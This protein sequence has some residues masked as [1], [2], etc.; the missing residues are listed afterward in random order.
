MI[1]TPRL[2]NPL[3]AVSETD[4]AMSKL[5]YSGLLRS[6]NEGIVPDLAARYEVSE[7]LLEYRFFLRDELKFHDGH[8]LTVDDIIFTISLAQ[9]PELKSPKR[10]NW[11][12]ITL[13]KISERE[14]VFKLDQPYPP[15][16]QNLDIGILP[17][18]VWNNLNINEITLTNININPV[19]SGPYKIARANRDELGI[20][21][22]YVLESF[23]DFAL[24]EPNIKKLTIKFAKN[25]NHLVEL[26]TN[27][28]VDSIY[29]LGPE[30]AHKLQLDGKRI[31]EFTLPRIFAIFLNQS[32]NIVLSNSAVRQALQL[33]TPRN[34]IVNDVLFG[35]ATVADGP[36]PQNYLDFLDEDFEMSSS[37]NEENNIEEAVKILE[38]N[39]W[40]K[41]DEGIMIKDSNGNKQMLSLTI[42]T[43]NAP[44]L[45]KI[46]EV[47][48]NSW[49]EIGAQVDVRVFN[50]SDLSGT[51]IRPRNF[52]ALLFGLIVGRDLDFYAFWHSSQRNDP[53]LNIT[54]YANIEVD[55]T[56]EDIRNS[57]DS[58]LIS[59]GIIKIQSEIKKDIPAIFI[60]SPN[61]I[62]LIPDRL[63]NVNIQNITSAE[64]RFNTVNDWYLETR[65]VWGFLIN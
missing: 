25:Q 40:E 8:P 17:M 65:K 54:S 32:E 22:L 59:S 26:F 24:G 41:N 57:N 64:E 20:P 52:E 50:Q 13:E 49:R 2:I 18:H 29:G 1:G 5:I 7:D 42:S 47:V 51:V 53:G 30:A 11:E 63:K 43:S 55:K 62:Y 4:K 39:G 61:F 16:L 3:L 60:Y 23:K 56:L 38:K 21:N 19:G 35:F 9:N 27:G 28:E 46:S 6:T 10:A 14:L 37:G 33:A 36:I 31:K 34:Q 44:E 48:A 12:G 58:E 15:F 45:V